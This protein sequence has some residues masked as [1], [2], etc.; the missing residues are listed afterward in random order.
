MQESIS[1]HTRM[2]DL[3]TTAGVTAVDIV[4]S[5]FTS[6]YKHVDSL[7]HVASP[8]INRHAQNS[9]IEPPLIIIES[10]RHCILQ[11]P[12]VLHH[13]LCTHTQTQMHITCD[14]RVQGIG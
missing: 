14:V 3:S 9:S 4:K 11:L 10:I 8:Q 2:H 6:V 13:S 12:P 1:Q 7:V 5:S